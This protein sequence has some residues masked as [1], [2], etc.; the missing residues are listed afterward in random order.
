MQNVKTIDQIQLNVAKVSCVLKHENWSIRPAMSQS[1]TVEFRALHARLL[2]STSLN[3][4][5]APLIN[6]RPNR[7]QPAW[8]PDD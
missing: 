6:L 1:V 7:V 2:Y 3:L 4:F 8:F 5:N